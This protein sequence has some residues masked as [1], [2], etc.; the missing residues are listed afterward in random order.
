MM[1][2]EVRLR[3]DP[4]GPKV[5]TRSRVVC[6]RTP[7]SL[8]SL[9]CSPSPA[10]WVSGLKNTERDRKRYFFPSSL[11]GNLDTVDP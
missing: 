10:K 4:S 2:V 6:G 7:E 9:W 11:L 3:V 8:R 1:C 5:E